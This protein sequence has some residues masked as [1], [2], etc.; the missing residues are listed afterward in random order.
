MRGIESEVG[1]ALVHTGGASS[2][3]ADLRVRLWTGHLRVAASTTV[4]TQLRDLTRSLGIFRST[5]GSRV[6]FPYPYNSLGEILP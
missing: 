4:E 3:V 5:W 1:A 2:L 6:S